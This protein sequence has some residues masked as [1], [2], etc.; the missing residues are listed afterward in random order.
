MT[1]LTE[2]PASA[3]L[4]SPLYVPRLLLYAS[5]KYRADHWVAVDK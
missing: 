2:A 3:R 1:G 4:R 5:L